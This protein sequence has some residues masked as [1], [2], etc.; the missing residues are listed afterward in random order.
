MFNNFYRF[1]CFNS[2]LLHYALLEDLC[3]IRST[4][5]TLRPGSNRDEVYKSSSVAGLL[6]VM[7]ITSLVS[8]T[9]DCPVYRSTVFLSDVLK[10]VPGTRALIPSEAP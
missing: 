8:S 10:L 3:V 4:L 5:M 9:F 2:S 7:Q 6:G 1:F